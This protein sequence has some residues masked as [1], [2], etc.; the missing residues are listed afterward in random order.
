M[1]T[2][3][4][5][6]FCFEALENT[7]CFCLSLQKFSPKRKKH[8]KIELLNKEICKFLSLACIGIAKFY[9]HKMLNLAYPKFGTALI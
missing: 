8:R 9:C 6:T 3:L 4:R 5:Q 7:D 2:A 1:P